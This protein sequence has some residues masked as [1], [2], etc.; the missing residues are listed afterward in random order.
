VYS[1]CVV[2]VSGVYVYVCS[3]CMCIAVHTVASVYI[4]M[5]NGLTNN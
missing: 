2:W 3:V 5:L 4:E 1:T